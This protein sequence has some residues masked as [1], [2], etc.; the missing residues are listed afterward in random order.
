M[1]VE[2]S[3]LPRCMF[4]SGSWPCKTITCLKKIKEKKNVCCMLKI[5]KK[6]YECCSV[7]LL[8][9]SSIAFTFLTSVDDQL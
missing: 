1:K 7:L 4:V 2:S 9:E 3:N 6:F 5:R 8:L